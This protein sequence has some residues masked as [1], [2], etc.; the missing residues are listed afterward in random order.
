LREWDG[1]GGPQG[2]PDFHIR[3]R[4]SVSDGALIFVLQLSLS[5]S[6]RAPVRQVCQNPLN[7]CALANFA[8]ER[9]EEVNKPPDGDCKALHSEFV[10]IDGKRY[11][12]TSQSYQ[13]PPPAL[14]MQQRRP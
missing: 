10:S 14:E 3:I 2:I 7:V 13:P 12:V 6:D 11:S 5:S 4:Y 8:I 1:L 9:C